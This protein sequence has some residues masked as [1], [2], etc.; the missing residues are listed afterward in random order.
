MNY[1]E[2]I[3]NFFLEN[4]KIIFNLQNTEISYRVSNQDTANFIKL[5]TMIFNLSIISTIILMV[6]NYIIFIFFNTNSKLSK[7]IQY[8]NMLIMSI[9][10]CLLILKFY[11]SLKVEKILGY[12]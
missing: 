3:N 9:N 5:S 4:I 6:I 2:I 8:F 11:I 7:I 10:L 12:F 1:I